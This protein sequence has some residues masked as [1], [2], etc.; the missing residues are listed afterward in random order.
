[1]PPSLITFRDPS[2]HPFDTGTGA[3]NQWQQGQ[4]SAGIGGR[5]NPANQGAAPAPGSLAAPR[6]AGGGGATSMLNNPMAGYEAAWQQMGGGPMSGAQQGML[7]NPGLGGAAA[8]QDF[9]RQQ[10]EQEQRA[11]RTASMDRVTGAQNDYLNDPNRS[12]SNSLLQSIMANPEVLSQAVQAMMMG[13]NAAAAGGARRGAEQGI[14]QNLGGEGAA[15]GDA[16]ATAGRDEAASNQ[17]FA[18]D[19]GIAA[20]QINRDSTMAAMNAGRDASTT[21]M[22]NRMP[23]WQDL[24]D[25]QN[26]NIR[27]PDMASGG[28]AAL[29]AQLQQGGGGAGGGMGGGSAGMPGAGGGS[30]YPGWNESAHGRLEGGNYSGRVTNNFGGIQLTDPTGGYRAGM[31][32]SGQGGRPSSGTFDGTGSGMGGA[33]YDAQGRETAAPGGNGWGGGMMAP[34]SPTMPSGSSGGASPMPGGFAGPPA[35]G[36]GAQQSF[37]QLPPQMQQML[38]QLA[39]QMAGRR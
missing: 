17:R 28:L 19:L 30:S 20:P 24:N 16:M 23:F 37:A 39:M 3:A 25:L 13:R 29:M 1:M 27:M 21:E 5:W 11:N 35:S 10:R 33:R 15:F 36:G 8:A 34:V 26:A 14:R 38:L 4:S 32:Y 22:R 6:P 7:A 18:T 2:Q 9:Y 12:V 31:D